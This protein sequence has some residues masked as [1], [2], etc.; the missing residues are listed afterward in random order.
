MRRSKAWTWVSVGAVVLMAGACIPPST[1]KRPVISTAELPYAVVGKPYVT[2]L[3]AV[4]STH[5]S[6]SLSG[7]SLPAGLNLN[8]AT[9]VVSGTPAFAPVPD[10]DYFRTFKV[11]A[12]NGS[13]S[14]SSTLRI[15]K[16][17]LST[18]SAPGPVSSGV[19]LPG[20]GTLLERDLN[21]GTPSWQQ[22][23][24]GSIVE[25]AGVTGG[26]GASLLIPDPPPESSFFSVFSLSR[27]LLARRGRFAD[28]GSVLALAGH[29]RHIA[30]DA[31][32][33][34]RCVVLTGLGSPLD[35]PL[36]GSRTCRR[37]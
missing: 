14:S 10:L 3:S 36:V 26:S 33:L 17:A 21:S 12:S 9:G 18:S 24:D 2:T 4:S 35:R 13:G 31:P 22:R 25:A 6:W 15:K 7:G 5:V 8:S 1:G 30:A 23:S 16:Y 20:G 29:C 34:G 19:T 32:R 27:G 37:P 28:P 11:T